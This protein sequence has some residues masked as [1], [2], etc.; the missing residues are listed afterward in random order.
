MDYKIDFEKIKEVQRLIRILESI[1]IKR[2]EYE[3]I[4]PYDRRI[5]EALW[6]KPPKKTLG[7]FK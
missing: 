5:H 6:I 2:K 7:G 1:G 4:S 3:L